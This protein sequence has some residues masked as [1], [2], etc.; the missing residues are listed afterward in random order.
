MLKLNETATPPITLGDLN[1]V[2]RQANSGDAAAMA[3]LRQLLDEYPRLW[4][5]QGDLSRFAEI[6]MI[7][8]VMGQDQALG[9]CLQRYVDYLRQELTGPS[10]TALEQLGAQRIL[11]AWMEVQFLNQ[12]FPEPTG[13]SLAQQT[14]VIKLKQAAE[15]RYD[16]AIKGWLLIKKLQPLPRSALACDVQLPAR[17]GAGSATARVNGVNGTAVNGQAK[18]IHPD[19]RTNGHNGKA[20][21][22]IVSA[23][24]TNGKVRPSH[25]LNVDANGV[26]A[27]GARL[28]K[29]KKKRRHA[30]LQFADRM[31]Q[32]DL[33]NRVCDFLG[34]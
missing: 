18:R 17:R 11:A 24:G 25:G 15:R 31:A 6:K 12:K 29:K 26:A 28:V 30:K 32:P 5:V 23:S 13:Q 10:P 21:P 34:S 3:R 4:L 1:T 16:M 20:V 14:Y 7:Q 27:N 19:T 8:H 33:G 2:M 9:E 22:A